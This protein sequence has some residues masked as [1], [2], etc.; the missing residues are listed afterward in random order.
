MLL[1]QTD[2]L[3]GN[4]SFCLWTW[5]YEAMTFGI[6]ASIS[7]H[8]RKAKKI[9]KR[10]G[11][12]W[13]CSV[14]A[15]TALFLQCLWLEIKVCLLTRSKQNKKPPPKL[16]FIIVA[17][18]VESSSSVQFSHSVMS[19]SL[20]PHESQ[21][22]TPPCPS[23]TPRVYPNSCSS[24]RWCHPIISSSVIPFSSCPQSLPA[25]GSFLMSQLF[26][27]G[28]QSIA[29]STSASILP[30]NTQQWSP[31]GW[32]GWI[33]LQSKGLSRVFSNTTVQKHQFFSTQLSL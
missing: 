32:T 24:S 7:D 6:A 4:C 25:T 8:E 16:I 17:V 26:A 28:G 29:V 31:L 5:S 22:A 10:L 14:A 19:N 3:R 13:L 1:F 20:G 21:H 33:S 2:T 15:V 9:P 23:P 27:W 12:T 18:V 30:M 11:L